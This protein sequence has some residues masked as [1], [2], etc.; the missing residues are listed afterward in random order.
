MSTETEQKNAAVDPALSAGAGAPVSA[1]N[2]PAGSGFGRRWRMTKSF[3]KE[4]M[5]EHEFW[6]HALAVKGGASAIVIAS[7]LTVS[8]V[9]AAP[10]MLA[11]AGIAAC[12]AVVG[13]GAYGIVAGGARSWYRLRKIYSNVTGKPLPP[14]PE[15]KGPNWWQRQCE[16]PAVR[17]VLETPV[18]KGFLNSRAWKMTKRLTA[19]QQDNVLG[20]IAVGGAAISLVLGAAA[21]ATQILVLPVVALG[22]LITV[23][24]VTATS[25]LVSGISGLYFGITGIRHMREKKRAKAA[26]LAAAEAQQTAENPTADL[27]PESAPPA[28]GTMPAA[29]DGFNAAARTDAGAQKQ[30]AA[31]GETPPAV[32]A[33]P[34]RKNI[35]GPKS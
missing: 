16:K 5:H 31:A 14:K 24:A 29:N 2:A 32:T 15:S 27:T 11:A 19:G 34:A 12:G 25:Y 28:A 13:I 1:D 3:A 35:A 8:Y 23:A 4:L 17:K 10:F 26:A 6:V 18:V 20:G 7:V 9:V 22:G 33:A 21:L 30:D